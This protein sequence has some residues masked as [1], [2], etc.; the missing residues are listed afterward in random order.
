MGCC[1]CDLD[2]YPLIKGRRLDVANQAAAQNEGER[3]ACLRSA[4]NEM[5][6]KQMHS[7]IRSEE[8]NWE[9][10]AV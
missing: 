10:E 4:R 1:S 6:E 7:P 3:K 5:C 2:E 9:A 8:C